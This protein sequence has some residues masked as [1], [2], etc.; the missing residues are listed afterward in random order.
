MAEK[1]EKV[2]SNEMDT[3]IINIPKVREMKAKSNKKRQ[4]ASLK[5]LKFEIN[6]AD[7]PLKTEIIK[8]INERNLTYGDLHEYCTNQIKGGDVAEGRKLGYNII[9]SIK[10]CHTMVDTTFALLCDFLNLDIC[11]V[12][13]NNIETPTDLNDENESEEDPK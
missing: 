2:P 5:P 3:V 12:D 8:R 10:S 7:S 6:P 9:S 13:R 1:K 4:N 11:L